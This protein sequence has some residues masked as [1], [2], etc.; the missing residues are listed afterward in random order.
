MSVKRF[1]HGT[2][3]RWQ[4]TTYKVVQILS[5]EEV[6]IE[7]VLRRTTIVVEILMLVQALF[8]GELYFTIEGKQAKENELGD[9]CVENEYL[10]LDDCPEELVAIAR[11]RLEVIQPLLDMKRRTRADVVA[12]VHQVQAVA[13]DSGEGLQCAVSVASVYRWIGD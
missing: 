13:K 8:D 2:Q 10:D 4:G 1:L 7:E 5:A 3:F 12:R 6:L 9:I 11:Y